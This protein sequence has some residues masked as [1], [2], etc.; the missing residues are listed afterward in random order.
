MKSL[1]SEL[2]I[3]IEYTVSESQTIHRWIW[4]KWRHIRIQ[5]MHGENV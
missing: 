1:Y 5:A 3:K 2:S 4:T